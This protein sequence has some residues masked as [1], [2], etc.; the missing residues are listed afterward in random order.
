MKFRQI[1]LIFVGKSEAFHG[2]LYVHKVGA[3]FLQNQVQENEVKTLVKRRKFQFSHVLV[4]VYFKRFVL[5]QED[6]YF[7]LPYV[8]VVVIALVTWL[9]PQTLYNDK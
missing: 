6:S 7:L 1:H 4:C 9:R 8:F 3:S 5:R 2:L